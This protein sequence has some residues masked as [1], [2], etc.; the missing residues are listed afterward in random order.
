MKRIFLSILV[1]F[2]ITIAS[3]A[4]VFAAAN[5]TDVK[6]VI[7]VN[8]KGISGASVV[9]VCNSQSLVTTTDTHGLYIVHFD[10]IDCAIGSKTTV[11]ATQHKLGG[12]NTGLVTSR[13]PT[14]V[15]INI[16]NAT[17]P[18]FGIIAGVVSIIVSGTAYLVIRRRHKE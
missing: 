15:N 18:E 9:V 10:A 6:G 17:V 12:V 1:A 3:S 16:V 5:T 7:T 8:N 4:S 13:A 2:G 14:T 11:V